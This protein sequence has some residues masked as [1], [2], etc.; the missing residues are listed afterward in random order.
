[1]L[2]TIVLPFAKAFILMVHQTVRKEC[3]VGG[4]L[5]ALGA[6][7]FAATSRPLLLGMAASN[8]LIT[9]NAIALDSGR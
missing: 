8:Q 6:A 1:L 3:A 9:R 4:F 5:P 2:K 7:R